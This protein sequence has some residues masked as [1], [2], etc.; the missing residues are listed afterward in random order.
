MFLFQEYEHQQLECGMSSMCGKLFLYIMGNSHFFDVVLVNIN[1]F[2]ES[3]KFFLNNLIFHQRKKRIIDH[4]QNN[5]HITFIDYFLPFLTHMLPSQLQEYLLENCTALL[6]SYHSLYAHNFF[7]IP[8][9]IARC[10]YIYTS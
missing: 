2:M 1:N 9:M 8:N 3:S 10:N 5:L 6:I 4:V 7:L